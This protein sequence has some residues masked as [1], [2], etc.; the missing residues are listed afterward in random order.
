MTNYLKSTL[1]RNLLA[2]AVFTAA[3]TPQ[4]LK[5]DDP[6]VAQLACA[7]QNLTMNGTYVMSGTGTI[8]G[9]GPIA[10]VG[11]V[12]YDG[13]GNGSVTY[14]VSLNGVITKAITATGTFTVNSDCTGSKTIGSGPSA[15]HFD[16][17]I[18]PDGGTITWVETDTSVV[19]MGTAVR[20]G[21]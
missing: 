18:T 3:L 4:A 6:R 11:K 10:L 1:N 13:R 2:L 20:F 16:F 21:R 8:V 17:V 9:V 19:M 14:T 12:T 7:F 15:T 5:A